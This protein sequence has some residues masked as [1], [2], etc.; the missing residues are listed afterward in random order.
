M[1]LQDLAPVNSQRPQQTDINA[2]FRFLMTEGLN[3]RHSPS[4]FVKLMDRF[5]MHLTRAEGREGKVLARNS[6]MSYLRHVKN[7]LFDTYLKNRASIEKRLIKMAQTLERHCRKRFEGGAS[8]RAP[9]CTKEDLRILID[10]LYF[11]A[12][13]SATL[14]SLP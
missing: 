4:K 12:A 1:S 3:M 6:V 11:D 13:S 9:A 5:A 7:W 8:K 10:G 2:F 14:R